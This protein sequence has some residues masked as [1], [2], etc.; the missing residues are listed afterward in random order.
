MPPNQGID[1]RFN[2]L[3]P[4]FLRISVKAEGKKPA[5]AAEFFDKHGK[6]RYEH[7]VTYSK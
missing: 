5:A 7:E 4:G 6:V 3:P 1:V 2:H